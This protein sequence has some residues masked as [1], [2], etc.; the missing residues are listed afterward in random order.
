MVPVY[1]INPPPFPK[2]DQNNAC[3][4]AFKYNPI[5]M[6]H[7]PPEMFLCK[8]RYNFCIVSCV[9][10]K[11]CVCSFHCHPKNFL[12]PSFA[13]QFFH[14]CFQKKKTWSQDYSVSSIAFVLIPQLR[15]S[16]PNLCFE[17]SLNYD[18]GKNHLHALPIYKLF[19]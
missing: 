10:F 6:K 17:K 9:S 11:T 18:S 5:L 7:P 2:Y 19:Q 4:L 3:R 16:H 12:P 13:S 1:P 15:S 8:N 14:T